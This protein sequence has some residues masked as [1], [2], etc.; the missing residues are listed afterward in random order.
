VY[1]DDL[2]LAGLGAQ[3]D[4]SYIWRDD[5]PPRFPI[6][7][8]HGRGASIDEYVDGTAPVGSVNSYR[9]IEI[10]RMSDE[11]SERRVLLS[12]HWLRYELPSWTVLVALDG[13]EQADDVAAALDLRQTAAGFPVADTSGPLALAVGFGEA[14]G[15]ELGIGDG[16]PDP[17]KSSLEPLILLS[18][19][20][21]V[22]GHDEIDQS[23]GYASLCL[24][25]QVFASIYGDRDFVKS[26]IEG[27]RV[28]DFVAA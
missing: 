1:P 8:L 5:P 23:G 10:W 27:L 14:E 4:V 16:W 17:S 9:G 28:E 11:W 6:I 25:G 2:D 13:P 20:G 26:V 15:P 7:F 3:P 19:E 21:C 12:G 22:M 18:P 24:G